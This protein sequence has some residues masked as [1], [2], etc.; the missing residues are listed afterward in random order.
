LQVGG[1][2]DLEGKATVPL[3]RP[4]AL[5]FEGTV[6]LDNLHYK[7]AGMTRP[8][9][10]IGGR[11]KVSGQRTAWEG[12]TAAI[13]RSDLA[14]T[15]TVEDYLRPRI[16]FDLASKRLDLNELIALQAPSAPGRGAPP[17]VGAGAGGGGGEAGLLSQVSAAGT[18]KAENL[19]FQNFDLTNV[20]GKVTL[21][22]SV[23]S[24]QGL[25]AAIAGGSI[26]GE[27][28][29]DLGRPKPA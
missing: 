19:R 16:G 6:T 28:G 1:G 20:R 2:A 23:A 14:G 15:L 22:D 7:D 10:K 18:L 5:Q 26:R 4:E 9:E 8:I 12:F 13:G 11:L 29:L 27:A 25:D 21:K 3:A 17:A 24:L